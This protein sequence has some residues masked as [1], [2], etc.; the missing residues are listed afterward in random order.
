MK[1]LK[2]DKERI[3][4]VPFFYYKTKDNNENKFTII[5]SH[6]NAEDI[7]QSI[8]WMRHM[9]DFLKADIVVYD[10]IGYGLAK[11]R[12]SEDKCYKSLKAIYTYLTVDKQIDSKN[13]ILY[14]RSLGSGPTVHFASNLSN[15][16]AGVIL[17]S[18]ISSAIRVV[19]TKLAAIPALDMFENIKKI[20]KIQC[21][22]FII[23]GDS[24]EVVPYWHGQELSTK[25]QPSN[26]WKFLTLPGAGHN[27][28]ES[29]EY[30]D[31]LLK[32]LQSFLKHLENQ[33]NA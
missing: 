28:I 5:Y 10:Y 9:R 22:I 6:G 29:E 25:V 21:P 20:H 8:Y 3:N 17:Q 32:N 4:Q 12:A 33:S 18:P 7:G 16:I 24:D 31:T 2:K 19:S 1:N 13:I 23:H 30:S 14:G 26:L 11:G 27:N 15:P